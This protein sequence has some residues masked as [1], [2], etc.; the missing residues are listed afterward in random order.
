MASVLASL[1]S[2]GVG[3]SGETGGD[4]VNNYTWRVGLFMLFL[5]FVVF[6]IFGLYLDKVLPRDYGTREPAWFLCTG[7]FWDCLCCKQRAQ[8]QIDDEQY[9]RRSQLQRRSQPGN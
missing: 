3:V 5:G 8:R 6:G 7:K 4:L 1:E 9:E 2:A